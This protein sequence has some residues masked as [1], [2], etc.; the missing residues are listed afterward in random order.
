MRPK[1]RRFKMTCG[2]TAVWRIADILGVPANLD[3]VMALAKVGE[4]GITVN[5]MKSLSDSLGLPGQ[6]VQLD[7]FDRVTAPA[8]LVLSNNHA[9]AFN[10]VTEEGM[11]LIY[12]P[13][14]GADKPAPPQEI[15]RRWTGV[16]IVYNG[17]EYSTAQMWS[18]SLMLGTASALLISAVLWPR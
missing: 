13:V 17:L 18:I 15:L 8:I 10:G 4:S 12:H 16:A 2:P 6:L 7:S 5:A 11:F 1:K 3:D 9:V 14:L